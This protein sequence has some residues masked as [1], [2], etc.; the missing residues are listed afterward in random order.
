[1]PRPYA[2]PVTLLCAIS[3]FQ[4]TVW[5]PMIGCAMGEA[6]ARRRVSM[7]LRGWDYREPCAYFVTMCTFNRECVL[8]TPIIARALRTEWAR[9]ICGSGQPEPYEF[10]VMPDH[11]HCIVWITRSKARARHSRDRG[12]SERVVTTDQAKP[13]RSTGASPLRTA[14]CAPGSL[15][16]KVG[17]FKSAACKRVRALRM[18]PGAPVWQGGFHDRVVRDERALTRA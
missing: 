5:V 8:D 10:V 15:G 6:S 7:R 4:L 14:G 11:V 12:Y 1:M 9:A 13:H 3:D 2:T 17:A 18:T 16:A